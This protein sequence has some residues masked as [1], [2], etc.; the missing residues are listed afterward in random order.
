MTKNTGDAH[1]IEMV[2]R[3]FGLVQ[4]EQSSTVQEEEVVKEGQKGATQQQEDDKVPV[5]D[6]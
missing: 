5:E 3:R 6:A 4:K 1:E 2:K